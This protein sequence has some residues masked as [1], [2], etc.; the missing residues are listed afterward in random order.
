MYR[1][2]SVIVLLNDGYEGGDVL[3]QDYTA[4]DET[5]MIYPKTKGTMLVFP[6][7]LRHAVTP[8]TKGERKSLVL[9]IHGKP[10]R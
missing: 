10:F 6:S 2:L 4:Q 3:F 5:K 7:F 1:K 8:V 9:W